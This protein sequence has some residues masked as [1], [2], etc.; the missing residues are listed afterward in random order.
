[1]TT[2]KSARR[3]PPF[4]AEH[5]GSLKRPDDLLKKRDELGEGTEAETQL[6]PIEDAAIRD[7]VKRQLDL[8][9]RCVSDGEYR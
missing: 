8:G 5:L 1:M 2:T 6:P 4:R 9:F 7:A 3:D